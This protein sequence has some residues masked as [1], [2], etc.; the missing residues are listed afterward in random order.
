MPS[1]MDKI[2]VFLT[3]SWSKIEVCRLIKSSQLLLSSFS[4][5]SIIISP[6]LDTLRLLDFYRQM[7]K[8]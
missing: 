7:K 3:G 2:V 1:D 6:T 8:V 4:L 5:M